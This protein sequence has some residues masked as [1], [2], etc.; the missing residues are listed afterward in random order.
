[1]RPIPDSYR[2]RPGRRPA[3]EYPGAK[4]DTQAHQEGAL[5]TT[6]RLR[7]GTADGWKRPPETRQQRQMVLRWSKTERRD[8]R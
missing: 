7:Q 2:G 3:G 4:D 8:R 6:V 5:A 1:M